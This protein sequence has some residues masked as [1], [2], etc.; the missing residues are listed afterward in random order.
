MELLSP[1][2]SVGRSVAWPPFFGWCSGWGYFSLSS[3]GRWSCL[4]G[5]VGRCCHMLGRWGVG[6]LGRV[7]ALFGGWVLC[8]GVGW[9]EDGRRLECSVSGLVLVCS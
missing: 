6:W 4:G 3:V 8:G 5:S 1:L 2:S 9:L 7:L